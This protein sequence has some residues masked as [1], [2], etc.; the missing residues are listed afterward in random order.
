VLTLA[1]FVL[2]AAEVNHIYEDFEG[3]TSLASWL[4]VV[5]EAGFVLILFYGFYLLFR[6]LSPPSETASEATG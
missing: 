1:P 5:L 2:A 3:P 4:H 6:A